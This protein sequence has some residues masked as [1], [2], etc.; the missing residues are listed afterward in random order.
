MMPV[1]ALLVTTKFPP[2]L[3]PTVSVSVVRRR[4]RSCEKPVARRA[5]R[6]SIECAA[7]GVMAQTRIPPAAFPDARNRPSRLNATL[8]TWPVC[9][10]RV[11]ETVMSRAFP[12][13]TLASLGTAMRTRSALYAVSFGTRERSDGGASTAISDAAPTSHMRTVP[14]RSPTT[15]VSPWSLNAI[16]WRGRRTGVRTACN[17]SDASMRETVWNSSNASRLTTTS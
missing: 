6:T 17:E 14:L 3:T 9:A 10:S 15:S 8:D 13:I 2:V 4:G 5:V 1:A 12:T 7:R 16:R 11:S